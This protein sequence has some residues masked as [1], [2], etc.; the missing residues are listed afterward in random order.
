M[1]FLCLSNLIL[2]T[3]HIV[4]IQMEPTEYVILT[5]RTYT[6]GYGVDKSQFEYS[7][8]ERFTISKTSADGAAVRS[9]IQCLSH[10][11]WPNAVQV[12]KA[13]KQPQKPQQQPQ[14]PQQQPQ[15]PQ[16]LRDCYAQQPPIDEEEALLREATTHEPPRHVSAALRRLNE[17]IRRESPLGSRSAS[18]Q[19]KADGQRKAV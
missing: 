11:A 19:L 10:Q 2:N 1:S 16:P 12:K 14:Q 6:A 7:Y 3:A 9:L 18:P 15:G 17:N 5:S 8:P 13:K 4:A